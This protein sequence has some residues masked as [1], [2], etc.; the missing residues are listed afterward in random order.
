MKQLSVFLILLCILSSCDSPLDID[1]PRE[2]DP[3]VQKDSVDTGGPLSLALV[4]DASGSMMGAGNAA[5]ISGATLLIDSLDGR[6]DQAAVLWFTGTVKLFQPMTW[7]RD[8]L[9]TAVSVLPATGATALWDGIHA[10]IREVVTN[11][12][13]PSRA[14][15][16]FSDGMD[17]ASTRTPQDVLDEARSGSVRL[18]F[19]YFGA[20]QAQP[21]LAILA[22]STRGSYSP[23]NS[24]A[25]SDSAYMR[26]LRSV[27]G[28]S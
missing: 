4:F 9:R 1:T 28:K 27:R 12:S 25:E 26:V 22:D 8:S 3:I 2:K 11:S 24:T 16:V 7:D 14:V 18:F 21:E 13:H 23:I 19:I 10:G 17:N 20:A 15:I 6:Q 5:A